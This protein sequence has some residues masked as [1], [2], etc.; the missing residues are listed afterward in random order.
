LPAPRD[1]A[2]HRARIGRP[3]L[4]WLLP[5]RNEAGALTRRQQ[6]P[7]ETKTFIRF[8]LTTTESPPPPRPKAFRMTTFCCRCNKRLSFGNGAILTGGS[9]G[10]GWASQNPASMRMDDGDRFLI[11]WRRASSVEYRVSLLRQQ[12]H[13]FHLQASRAN[14]RRLSLPRAVQ[15]GE[16]LHSL[17]GVLC[18]TF[19]VLNPAAVYF[20]PE[21]GRFTQPQ[22]G[23]GVWIRGSFVHRQ[24]PMVSSRMI[25]PHAQDRFPKP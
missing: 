12:D 10:T 17:S 11:G 5:S 2:L 9:L 20:A 25:D 19:H 14:F 16:T 18:V 7:P 3:S 1:P 23:S 22:S 15:Q 4:T 13:G 21:S 24:V 6:L 8:R